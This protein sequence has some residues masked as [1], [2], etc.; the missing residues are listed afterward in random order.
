VRGT[1]AEP[2]QVKTV[3]LDIYDSEGNVFQP[4]ID[5]VSDYVPQTDIQVKP[6]DKGVFSYQFPLGPIVLEKVTGTYK[7]EATYGSATKN[8][9][10]LVS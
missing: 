3:R 6:N 2:V 1:L 5:S 8:A 4:F 7:I 10:F 9:I